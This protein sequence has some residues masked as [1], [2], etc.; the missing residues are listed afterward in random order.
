MRE[1]PQTT[2]KLNKVRRKLNVDRFEKHDF[3]AACPFNVDELRSKNRKAE[4]L[5]WR[6][7]AITWHLLC[8][9]ILRVAGEALNRDHATS[10][11]SLNQVHSAILG[12]GMPQIR[13]AIQDVVDHVNN[14]ERLTIPKDRIAHWLS[15][16]FDDS[17]EVDV[18]TEQV[19]EIVNNKK[20][21]D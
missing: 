2:L 4:I 16:Y 6:H 18:L 21:L 15:M 19:S 12:Y 7:V 11:N 9:D 10:I 14:I 17:G 5:A 1:A 8:G 3:Y 20:P 13:Q